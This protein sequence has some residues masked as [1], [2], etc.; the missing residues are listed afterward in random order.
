MRAA[1][2]LH[3][4]KKS[5]FKHWTSNKILYDTANIP[6]IDNFIIKT[7]RNYFASLKKIKNDEIQKLCELDHPTAIAAAA[8]GC[9]K[10]QEFIYHDRQ[11][12]VRNNYNV[13][14][15]YHWKRHRLCI[16]L[17]TFN[18]MFNKA[19][20]KNYSEVIPKCGSCMEHT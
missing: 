18:E 20:S 4:S 1:L 7:T 11:G 3:K 8:K 16:K 17:P 2:K 13:P 10:P 12:I 9:T 5:N 14:I 19:N 15:I 6:R